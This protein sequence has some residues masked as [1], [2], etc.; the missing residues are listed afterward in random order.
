MLY[1]CFYYLLDFLILWNVAFITIFLFCLLSS[2]QYPNDIV[3]EL[4][5]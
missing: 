4:F 5:D 1:P 3:I 2:N